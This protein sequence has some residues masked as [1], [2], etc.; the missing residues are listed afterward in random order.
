MFEWQNAIDGPVR[1]CLV[2]LISAERIEIKIIED[3]M[4]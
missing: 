2:L 1:L 4:K 3:G